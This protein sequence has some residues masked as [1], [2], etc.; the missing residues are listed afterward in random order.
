MGNI[1]DTNFTREHQSTQGMPPTID[2]LNVRVS[3]AQQYS[4]NAQYNLNCIEI[5][6]ND[7][8]MMH[9]GWSAAVANMLDTV[10]KF[11]FKAEIFENDFKRY[12]DGREDSISLL[13]KYAIKFIYFNIIF[14]II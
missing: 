14:V 5:L 9:Q 3:L 8:H 7:Q 10:E 2:A 12:L 6:I 11:K 4:E 13:N 1:S